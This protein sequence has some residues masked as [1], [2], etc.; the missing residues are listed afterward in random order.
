MIKDP[1]SSSSIR[2][3]LD[4]Q[5]FIDSKIIHI[6]TQTEAVRFLESYGY[7]LKDVEDKN[8]LHAIR[9]EAIELIQNELLHPHELIPFSVLQETDVC[10]LLKIA[11]GHT[12]KRD[13][14]W[15]GAILRV[16][17][18]LAHSQSYLNDLYHDVIRT[19]ILDRFDRVIETKNG[20]PFIG[21]IVLHQFEFRKAKS[22]WSAALKL[23]HK[24]ENVAAD[25][26][27]W[28]GV[29]FVTEYRADAIELLAYLR[30]EHVIAFANIK[31]SRSRNTLIS[32]QWVDKMAEQGASR[33]QLHADLQ[34][35]KYPTD[36]NQN[37]ENLFSEI[38]YHSIQLTC[39][40]RIKIRQASGKRL[41]FFFPFEL[42]I[43]DRESYQRSREGLAS[44]AEYKKRQKIAVRKR[45]L[46]FLKS[47]K[48]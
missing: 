27:D 39:R 12:N 38:S 7:D 6:H 17:H 5:S 41:S 42:Q 18:T 28:I 47:R 44:H 4:G 11:S 37:K 9:E 35:A 33:K 36:H 1:W 25:I 34:N 16:M 48:D 46:P 24:A 31:P 29:R 8:E 14:A 30:N 45:I 43:M 22:R 2:M 21:P 13:A 23:M 10:N 3:A 19:Q 15:A 40:Q 20:K 26:F 32:F